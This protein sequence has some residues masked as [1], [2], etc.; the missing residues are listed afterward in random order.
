MKVR[1]DPCP[2]PLDENPP[3]KAFDDLPYDDN[4]VLPSMPWI[5]PKIQDESSRGPI[6]NLPIL[7]GQPFKPEPNQ[8]PKKERPLD[9]AIQSRQHPFEENEEVSWV[10]PEP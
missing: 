2:N 9:E 7:I 3:K 4:E 10:V 6:P 1:V 5:E 8:K